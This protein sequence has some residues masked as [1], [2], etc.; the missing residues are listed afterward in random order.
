MLTWNR[1]ELFQHLTKPFVMKNGPLIVAT[2][3][4][5]SFVGD[6]PFR[7]LAIQGNWNM[8]TKVQEWNKRV[9][10]NIFAKKELLTK[11]RNVKRSLELFRALDNDDLGVLNAK[12][13]I[14]E[15]RK[16]FFSMSP[17]KALRVDGLHA[18]FY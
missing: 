18:K 4:T 2:D 11:L 6:K 10:G 12:V 17:L 3:S 14:N 7:F 15:V 8:S 1:G 13:S 16:V 9:F 5:T